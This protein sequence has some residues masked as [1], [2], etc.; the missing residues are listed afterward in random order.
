MPTE[1]ATKIVLQSDLYTNLEDQVHK[2][3]LSSEAWWKAACAG[4]SACLHMGV[5]DASTPAL[6]LELAAVCTSTTFI[7]IKVG[8][9]TRTCFSKAKAGRQ[10]DRVA[11]NSRTCPA[12]VLQAYA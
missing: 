7:I 4:T 5:V 3:S 12:P 9:E 2:T 6:I 11:A 1:S 10:G 8:V